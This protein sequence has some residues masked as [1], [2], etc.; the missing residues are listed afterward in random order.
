[1]QFLPLTDLHPR[2]IFDIIILLQS[3]LQKNMLVIAMDDT[4]DGQRGH[5]SGFAGPAMTDWYLSPLTGDQREKFACDQLEVPPATAELC[6]GE[7]TRGIYF[8]TT[9]SFF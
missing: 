9:R 7:K 6:L 8:R 5:F 4:R 2:Y 1:M 3:Q